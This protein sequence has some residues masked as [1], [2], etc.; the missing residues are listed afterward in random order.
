MFYLTLYEWQL[1]I[2]FSV[3]EKYYC[4]LLSIS[5]SYDYIDKIKMKEIL[6]FGQQNVKTQF[7]CIC[8]QQQKDIFCYKNTYSNDTIATIINAH[9]GL[10]SEWKWSLHRL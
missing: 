6:I 3:K 8:L 4:T 2:K 7:C 1:G 9:F 10:Q 5:T